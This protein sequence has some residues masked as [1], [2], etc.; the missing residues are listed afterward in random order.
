MGLRRLVINRI[1]YNLKYRWRSAR[2][3]EFA[4]HG[5]PPA[6]RW[7]GV[8]TH[9]LHTHYSTPRGL[10]FEADRGG[11]PDIRASADVLASVARQRAEAYRTREL[12]LLVGDDF[13]WLKAGLMFDGWERTIAALNGRRAFL[14]TP[15]AYFRALEGA[16]K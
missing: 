15:A 4:W 9:V 12:L 8:L 14:S 11:R 7:G 1:N 13:R 10:D 2:T 16:R 6:L 5:A 3:L